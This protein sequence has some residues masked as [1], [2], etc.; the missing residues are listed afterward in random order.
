MDKIDIIVSQTNY[1]KEIAIEKLS[2]YNDDYIKVIKEY[3]GVTE[4]PVKKSD[5]L[6]YGGI[7][8]FVFILLAFLVLLALCTSCTCLPRALA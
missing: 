1:T 8:L 2:Q 7:I 3:L 6:I 4:K 5:A